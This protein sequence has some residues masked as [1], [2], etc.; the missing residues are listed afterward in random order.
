M[1]IITNFNYFKI[2]EET[3]KDKKIFSINPHQIGKAKYSINM[4]DGKK[5]KDG[6]PFIGI[7]IAKTK[8][9]LNTKISDYKEGGYKEVS[10]VFNYLDKALK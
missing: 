6:S 9:E 1:S 2:N 3:I 4:Y 5:H 7:D 10:D 8:K